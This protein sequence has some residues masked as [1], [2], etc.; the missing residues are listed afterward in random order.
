MDG[1]DS[2]LADRTIPLVPQQSKDVGQIVAFQ[3][4]KSKTTLQFH[5]VGA[6]EQQPQITAA[7][8]HIEHEETGAGVHE[9]YLGLAAE[10]E[11]AV[12][13]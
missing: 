2:R 6:L 1:R 9:K 4:A 10:L 3:R 8:D 13:A 12:T 7:F 5:V 11:K